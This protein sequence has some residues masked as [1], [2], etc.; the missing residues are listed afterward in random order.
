MRET[1]LGKATVSSASRLAAQ[2]Y[3]FGVDDALKGFIDGFFHE[4]RRFIPANRQTM[5]ALKLRIYC[6]A[7]VLRVL[8]TEAENDPR[9]LELV[10]AFEKLIF[11]P[12]Q[13]PETMAK[14]EAVK[15]AM[16]NIDRLIFEGKQFS[17]ARSWFAGIGQNETNPATLS[18]LVELMA[19]NTKSLR[20]LVRK[21]G[22]TL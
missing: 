12:A 18:L 9:Y 22:T 17:W 7:D 8:L 13:T 3:Q 5:S 10:R 19:L 15:S 16:V 4:K 6:E 1:N 21:I 14:L 20:E 2:L 11:S